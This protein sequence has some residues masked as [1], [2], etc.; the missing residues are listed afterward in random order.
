MEKEE[1]LNA[2]L[3]S[4]LDK[5]LTKL[6]KNSDE[7][8]K[9]I[10]LMKSFFTKQEKLINSYKED[11]KRKT[12]IKQKTS[13]DLKKNK[14]GIRLFTPSNKGRN[15]KSKDKY[16]T[17]N[18]FSNLNKL[19]IDGNY[20]H[21]NVETKNNKL[22]KINNERK[23]IDTPKKKHH[24]KL[25]SISKIK[26]SKKININNNNE[27]KNITNITNKNNRKNKIGAFD[28]ITRTNK[29]FILENK[30]D[31]NKSN[32]TIN[33][34]NTNKNK[35][36]KITKRPIKIKVLQKSKTASLLPKFDMKKKKSDKI[37]QNKII[38]GDYICSE[39]GRNI[40][41]S[42]SNY[43]DS[44]STY[45]LFSCK[46]SYLKYLFRYI[47]D[48]YTEFKEKNKIN[49][50]T[51]VLKEKSEND[52]DIINKKFNLSIGTLKALE[53]LNKEE[54]IKFFDIDKYD[55]FSDDIYLVYKIIFQLSKN[56]E[57]K[58]CENKE[59]F[60]EKMVK[61]IKDNIKENKVGN[62]FKELANNFD[63]SKDNILQIKDIIKGNVDKLKPKYYSKICA[64]T[65]LIIFLVKDILE[66]LELTGNN[67]SNTTLILSNLAKSNSIS[68]SL[69]ICLIALHSIP[70]FWGEN[71]AFEATPFVVSNPLKALSRISL[72][73]ISI[74]IL[75]FSFLTLS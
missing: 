12:M 54:H 37:I 9:H 13:D 52:F 28:A 31:L 46:K 34:Y 16:L 69:N 67:K 49:P 66:Y 19:K 73:S 60:Y 4:L 15:S 5:S 2:L 44:K 62:L 45:N 6:E 11:I 43:L 7:E 14:K 3:K 25:N 40:I 32:N 30:N 23:Y 33:N 63:F 20:K 10:K 70:I 29:S 36:K 42:I 57:I 50:H 55:S 21:K 8:L 35:T 18:N 27:N 58:N 74:I 72:F 75:L 53:L 71:L 68:S 41:I 17:N 39:D 51:N 64:T 47:D 26:K 48:K 1:I 24:S 22:I 59:D 65:G 38:F 56:D 61:Y